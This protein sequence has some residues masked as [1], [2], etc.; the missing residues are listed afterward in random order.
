MP[1]TMKQ[2]QICRNLALALIFNCCFALFR[3]FTFLYDNA[4][5]VGLSLLRHPCFFSSPRPRGLYC[6]G[7][8]RLA[9]GACA[10]AVKDIQGH[11]GIKFLARF[12]F[13]LY[14]FGGLELFA[15]MHQD[16]VFRGQ[17]QEIRDALTQRCSHNKEKISM[18]CYFCFGQVKPTEGSVREPGGTCHATCVQEHD[19][20]TI[21]NLLRCLSARQESSERFD[22]LFPQTV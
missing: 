12:V 7:D 18:R 9:A 1:I 5:G 10:V 19:R 17:D 2:V 20:E 22:M 16:P 8:V 13:L 15:K 14:S 21:A 11:L 4:S 6:A 3:L